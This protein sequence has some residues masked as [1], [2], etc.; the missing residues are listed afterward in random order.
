MKNHT[1]VSTAQE[2]TLSLRDELAQLRRDRN[3]LKRCAAGALETGDLDAAV[4]YQRAVWEM[5]ITITQRMLQVFNTRA[6]RP[7][8][9]E[10]EPVPVATVANPKGWST[11]ETAVA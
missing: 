5:E 3:N 2:G 1:V 7:R 11:M 6:A 8:L 9:P 4:K 10:P